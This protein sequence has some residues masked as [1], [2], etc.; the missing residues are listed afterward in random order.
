MYATAKTAVTLIVIGVAGYFSR[1]FL[2]LYLTHHLTPI[3]YGDF[4]IAM[5][6]L[7]V[8]A[9]LSLLG[10]DVSASRFLTIFFGDSKQD[11][12]YDYIKWNLQLVSVSFMCCVLIAI[13]ALASMTITHWIGIKH[14][15]TY[16]L[17]VY[18]LWVAPFS[19]LVSLFANFLLGLKL[20]YTSTINNAV[21]RQL[22]MLFFIFFAVLF[23]DVSLNN[24]Q[25]TVLIF[26]AMVSLVILEV[27]QLRV[28]APYIFNIDLYRF[29]RERKSYDKQWL[30]TSLNLIIINLM[31]SIILF[32][33]IVIVKLF[34]PNA[35]DTGI[36]AI[37]LMI[38]SV[39]YIITINAYAH[40]QPRISLLIKTDVGKAQLQ[41][42]FNKSNL[43]VFA[44]LSITTFLLIYFSKSLLQHFGEHYQH[45]QIPLIILI[46]A[47]GIAAL[48]KSSN[49]IMSYSG[50]EKQLLN[51]TIFS[52]ILLLALL[53]PATIFYGITGTAIATVV[54]CVTQTALPVYLTRKNFG[55][56]SLWVV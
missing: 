17:S 37:A 40:I 56:K 51:A 23:F 14:I 47:N 26:C 22:L 34:A 8:M 1:Y 38:A 53:I 44:I 55:I 12:A 27:I 36:Y 7:S 24:L 10:T 42:L 33:E 13:I 41:S 29:W 35:I 30:S 19:A 3:Q 9:T 39:V 50:K 5:R 11:H 15:A 54:V 18:M 49:I 6:V 28:N 45:A 20:H 31:P 46:V 32:A 52:F 2:A 4:V 16:H 21:I 25:I 48:A 43:A